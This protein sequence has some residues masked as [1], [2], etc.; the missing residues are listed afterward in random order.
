MQQTLLALLAI[1][2][3]TF[4]SFNQKQGIVQSRSQVVRA[5]MEQ[6]ALGVAKQAMQT[7]RSRAFDQATVEL[8]P[9]SIVATSDLE[10]RSSI[11]SATKDCK[12]LDGGLGGICS[13]IDDFHGNMATITFTFPTGSFDFKIVDITVRYVDTN[14][15]PTG[16][17]R[18]TQKEI[19]L[20]VQDTPSSRA[21]RLPEPIE[22][23]EVVSYP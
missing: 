2:L 3:A 5:E 6:M 7:I 21:P 12:A 1:L 15:Q 9:D 11:R 18:S 4:L 20:K 23:S 10:S 8:P 13:D 16:G 22:Y 17:A 19:V 14:L